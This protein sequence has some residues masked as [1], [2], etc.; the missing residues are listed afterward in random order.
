MLLY[1][2]LTLPVLR[3][4]GGSRLCFYPSAA[5]ATSIVVD[6]QSHAVV[7]KIISVQTGSVLRQRFS[8]W[9]CASCAFVPDQMSL[10]HCCLVAASILISAHAFIQPIVGNSCLALKSTTTDAVPATTAHTGEGLEPTACYITNSDA[11]NMSH[12]R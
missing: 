3:A 8:N 5:A 7:A 11:Q 2:L 9:L 12:V 10:I 6:L 1:T 4:N